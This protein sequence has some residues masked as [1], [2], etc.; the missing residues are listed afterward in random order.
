MSALPPKADVVRRGRDVRSVPGPDLKETPGLGPEAVDGSTLNVP[1]FRNER[2]IAGL[3]SPPMSR[4]TALRIICSVLIWIAS[5]V[6]LSAATWHVVVLYDERLEFP[7][8][9]A[10]DGD[11]VRT[12]VSKSADSIEIYRET[13]DLS[14]FESDSYKIQLRDFLREKYFDKKIDLAIAVMGPSLDFL[15][16]YGDAIF[17]G[18][19]VV[20]CGID[21]TELGTRSIPP[22]VRGVLVKR[23]FAP[24]LD[25]VLSVHPGTNRVVVVAGTSEFDSRLLRQ[26]RQ[27]FRPYEGR[28]VFTYLNTLPLENM[29]TQ[30]S[31]LPPRTIVLFTTFFRDGAGETFVSHDVVERVSAVSS[32]PT[33]GFLDQYLG[34]GIVGG[35]VYSLASHGT[36][37]A[38][39][40]LQVLAGAE[41]SEV[42]Y[43]EVETNKLLFDWR[44]MRRWGITESALPTGSEIL[45][46]PQSTWEQYKTQILAATAIVL[47]QASL[48]GWLLHERR[49]RQRAEKVTHDTMSELTQEDRMATAGELSAT[50]AHEVNQPLASIVT[51][52]YA[53][54]RWLSAETPDLSK[55]RDALNQIV[56]AGHRASE[57]I[58]S[59]RAMFRKDTNEKGPVDINKLIRSVLRLV[60]ADLQKHGIESQTNLSEQLPP[61]IGDKVQLQQ[62]VLNLVV[63]AVDAMISVEPRVLSIKSMCNGQDCIHISIED[64][65]TG[66]DPSSVDRIFK[67]LFTTKA[68]GMGMGL[69]ICHS[70][71]ESHN[72]R[73]WVSAGASRGTIF[74]VELPTDVTKRQFPVTPLMGWPGRAPAPPQQAKLARDPKAEEY[75]RPQG[76][77]AGPSG[78]RTDRSHG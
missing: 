49:S 43:S 56:T 75:A 1:P 55:A 28:V 54:L 24:T 12:L 74:H 2:V 41:V 73:I 39:L 11:L 38:K 14:R 36:E 44:Q 45:F 26:A 46:R 29:L 66:I 48:I 70:I 78:G 67:P 64:T 19:P 4:C 33:Y 68:R 59:V 37:T 69:S 51:W 13:M 77:A 15:L 6:P 60:Y 76:S 32:A 40:A 27:E 3:N 20:F 58:T 9:A 10:L 22:H 72:G 31:Q 47:L 50:I 25:V 18:T 57:V 61:V 52:A 71:I 53:A 42:P 23:E 63:N 30:L 7:G 17:P 62:V 65:G 21:R 34:R 35:S 8:L 16:S 5:A